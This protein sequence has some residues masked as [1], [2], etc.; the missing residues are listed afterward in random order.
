MGALVR[1]L[2]M[3]LFVG[4]VSML[5]PTVSYAHRE[6]AS[7]RY[8]HGASKARRAYVFTDA[9]DIQLARNSGSGESSRIA[10]NDL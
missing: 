4:A 6:T 7:A 8:E 1:S 9:A 3:T 5:Y 10:G 2:P